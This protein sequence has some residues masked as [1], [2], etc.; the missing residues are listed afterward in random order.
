MSSIRPRKRSAGHDDDD[1]STYLAQ[2]AKRVCLDKVPPTSDNKP[3]PPAESI[4]PRGMPIASRNPRVAEPRADPVR[5]QASLD[6][7]PSALPL[8]ATGPPPS[9]NTIS[10]SV[11]KTGLR[12]PSDNADGGSREHTK[13]LVERSDRPVPV[14]PSSAQTHSHDKFGK[15]PSP[16][17][18][19]AISE[20]PAPPPL[21]HVR[22]RRSI[23]FTAP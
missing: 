20:D 14:D 3:K 5:P 15:V 1:D 19:T 9:N 10:N 18:S 4:F 6:D 17:I 12:S 13:S 11:S 22:L 7:S 23:S 8:M 21:T 16:F 2:E